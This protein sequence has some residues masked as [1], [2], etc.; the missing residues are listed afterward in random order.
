MQKAVKKALLMH[1]GL[2]ED[3]PIQFPSCSDDINKFYSSSQFHLSLSEDNENEKIV[4]DFIKKIPRGFRN[5][6]CKNVTRY[7]LEKPKR[8]QCFENK[9]TI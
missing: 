9:I 6:Y 2:I 5:S 8:F 7:Y 1:L 3:S 4:A